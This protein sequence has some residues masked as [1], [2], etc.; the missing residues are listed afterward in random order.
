MADMKKREK[1]FRGITP[2][3]SFKF[4]SLLTP[5]YGTD[6]HPKPDGEYKVR[7]VLSREAAQPLLKALEPIHA[8]AVEKGEEEFAKLKIEQ[9]KKLK[10]LSV[11]DL[12]AVE[13]D[14][15]TEEPT[16]NLLFNFKMKAG[17][18]REVR[19]AK[20]QWEQ[21]PALFD[22]AGKPLKGVKAIW[23][24][25]EGKVSFTANPYFVAGTGTAGLSLRLEAAQILEL[26]GPGQR[27]A[28][29]YGFGAE[30][31]YVGGDDE[32]LEGEEEGFED[33]QESPGEGDF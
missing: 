11:N 19:G 1:P 9:R 31:G 25:T 26:A 5:D 6:E 28:A 14:Q 3:G 10:S 7:L 13:Y 2:R 30:E 8:K 20:E 32:E 17:G 23:S 33:T 29:G 4:P 22:A 27:N 18:T 12:Y 16:G 21:R 24:G 15:E